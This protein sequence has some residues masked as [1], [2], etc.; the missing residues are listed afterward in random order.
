M[1][2]TFGHNFFAVTASQREKQMVFQPVELKKTQLKVA[3]QVIPMFSCWFYLFSVIVWFLK[4][5]AKNL[6]W[7]SQVNFEIPFICY[8]TDK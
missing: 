8:D 5:Y 3:V 6:R 2:G 7:K 1:E 4:M